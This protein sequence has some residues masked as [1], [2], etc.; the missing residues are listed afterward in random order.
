MFL[1]GFEGIEGE[2]NRLNHIHGGRRRIQG[3]NHLG[4]KDR[5]GQ[6]EWS[7]SCFEGTFFTMY[8]EFDRLR[9]Y[10]A[11]LLVLGVVNIS[12]SR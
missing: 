12:K 3:Q 6:W 9:R 1:S 11:G 10:G 7:I 2:L 4:S 8:F 5:E